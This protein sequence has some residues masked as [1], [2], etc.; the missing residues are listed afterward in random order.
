MHLT[1]KILEDPGSREAWWG[2]GG[3]ILMEMREEMWDAEH[4]EG[5]TGGG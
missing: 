2:R 3:D 1:L 4:L 5:G